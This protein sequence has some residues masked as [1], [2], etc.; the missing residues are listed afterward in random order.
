MGAVPLRLVRIKKHQSFFK[1]WCKRFYALAYAPAGKPPK[2]DGTEYPDSVRGAKA[3]SFRKA[4][5]GFTRVTGAPAPIGKNIHL[6]VPFLRR[7]FTPRFSV[8]ARK[9]PCEPCSCM[10]YFFYVIMNL[11]AEFVK[12]FTQKSKSENTASPVLKIPLKALALSP[13]YAIIYFTP[14]RRSTKKQKVIL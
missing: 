11:F 14:K 7:G 1:P 4:F 5:P 3:H 8:P 12:P 9:S 6:T 10:S 2:R 13:K